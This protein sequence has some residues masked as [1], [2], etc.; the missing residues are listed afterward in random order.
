MV[1]TLMDT[2]ING[3]SLVSERLLSPLSSTISPLH[4]A[5][6]A[7]LLLARA[8]GLFN[9]QYLGKRDLNLI[10]G[11]DD[12]IDIW[13]YRYA[14]ER[15]GIAKR[16]VEIFPRAT[17]SKGFDVWETPNL[18]RSTSFEKAVESLLSSQR[19]GVL[20]RLLRASI[21]A[22]LGE[23]SVLLI[24]APGNPAEE[25]PRG[26]NLDSISYL[27]PLG[28]DKVTVEKLVGEI[29][30]SEYDPRF[31]LP[32]YYQV[33]LSGHTGTGQSLAS[34]HSTARF[35][36]IHWTRVIHLV[37]CPL[38]NEVYGE[39]I[40]RAVW[41]LLMDLQK[42]TG[43]LSEAA[44]RRGWPGLHANVDKDVALTP[45]EKTAI[46]DNLDDYNIGMMNALVTRKTELS[47]IFAT[48]QIALK[49]NVNA[50]I[51]QIA[52]TIG[53]PMR[54][55]LGSERGDLASTQDRSNFSD[56]IMEERSAHNESVVRQ[57]L[58]RLY[59]YGYL[60]TPRNKD[61][62][63][64]WPEEEELDEKEKAEVAKLLTESKA[65]NLDEIRDRIWKMEPMPK[66]K[67]EET[68]IEEDKGE[69]DIP[70]EDEEDEEIPR[71]DSE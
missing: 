31:G 63:I 58:S 71:E 70:I 1:Y 16:I 36:R 62:E 52:G 50:I 39:P 14:Y 38:D 64:H 51:Q 4:S 41:N 53:A 13:Q 19:L 45:D 23:F 6:A 25:L 24:G 66:D 43:G 33:N 32:L 40:L 22:Y 59:D 10:L 21:L 49:E 67:E 28:Q 29:P 9:S 54:L 11:Y 65:M 26:T 69:E 20:S 37:H 57:F 68:V 42:L 60:P 18:K 17:W 56:R 30:G 61:Y 7:R 46:K 3:K 47:P 15:G 34:R 27:L 55:V 5:L 2:P 8:N 48:G 44:L 12:V 35:P